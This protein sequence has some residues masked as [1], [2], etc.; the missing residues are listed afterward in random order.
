MAKTETPKATPRNI[1]TAPA[2]AE[3]KND[4]PTMRNPPAPPKKDK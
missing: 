4:V 3:I 1:P 2:K